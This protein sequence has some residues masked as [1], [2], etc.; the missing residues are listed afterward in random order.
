MVVKLAVLCEELE[1]FEVREYMLE[2]SAIKCLSLP[3]QPL[4]RVD[5]MGAM[6]YKVFYARACDGPQFL[7]VK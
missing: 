6:K 5:W 7:G 4:G 3:K 1:S 2:Q